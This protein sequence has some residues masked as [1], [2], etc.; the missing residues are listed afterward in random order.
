LHAD[1]LPGDR[2]FSGW[3]PLPLSHEV[4]KALFRR[5]L[6]VLLTCALAVPAWELGRL[7][8]VIG[9]PVFAIVL[10]MGLSF[11]RRPE[12]VEEGI[13]FS[14][15]N[16]LQYSIIFL[17]F[18]LDLRV[19]LRVGG[20]S[21]AV[22]LFTLTAAFLTA[23]LVGKA[24]GLDT[25]LKI[26]IGVGTSIC[27]GSAI[28]AAAPVIGA[29]DRDVTYA[30][31]TIF[32]FNIVAVFLF[33]ALGHLMGMSA[34]QF[35]LWAGTAIN[36]TSSVVAAAFSYGDAA[37]RYATVV[38]LTRTLMIIPITLVLAFARARSA[39]G[40]KLEMVKIIPW[41]VLGFLAAS[42]V[43]SLGVLPGAVGGTLSEAG[44]FGICIAMAA[45]GLNANPVKLMQNGVRPVLL[46]LS[47]WAAVALVSLA[48]QQASGL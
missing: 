35:G 16:V 19:V 45:I 40:G 27:G 36:D 38:K 28:A 21:L 37:G 10:G 3:Y 29:D 4:I 44:K 23:Y 30:I 1:P 41:F 13:R 46:G 8:P 34:D 22:M 7:V 6:G 43:R 32:L 31:S 2:E 33:P 25:N 15:R 17:G 39:A 47:C 5:S 12:I 20:Q 42:L 11:F 48:V 24:L 9:A 18:S 26:L 14:A